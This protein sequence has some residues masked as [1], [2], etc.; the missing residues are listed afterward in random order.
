MFVVVFDPYGQ[1]RLSKKCILAIRCARSP[2]VTDPVRRSERPVAPRPVG[3]PG[4]GPASGAAARH[5]LP[6]KEPLRCP[7][8]PGLPGAQSCAKRSFEKLKRRLRSSRGRASCPWSSGF[9]RASRSCQP[10]A[11][12]AAPC[13]RVLVTQSLSGETTQFRNGA[14]IARRRRRRDSS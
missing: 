5:P 11:C 13:L 7:Y 2:L 1:T 9:C 12:V 3:A 14:E 8:L 6:P 10:V 4:R